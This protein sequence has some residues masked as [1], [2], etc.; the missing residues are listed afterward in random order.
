MS[1]NLFQHLRTVASYCF[2]LYLLAL[3]LYVSSLRR[4]HANLLWHRCVYN[5]KV[6]KQ[7]LNT[8]RFSSDAR[9]SPAAKVRAVRMC[10]A[11]TTFFLIRNH[12]VAYKVSQSKQIVGVD[13]PCC[14]EIPSIE[15]REGPTVTIPSSCFSVAKS[16][17]LLFLC[18]PH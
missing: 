11:K 4:G 7:S 12:F 15:N 8:T 17:R 3:D 13:Y 2:H 16:R 1:V 6:C 5:I 18:A 10:Y 14:I 9:F